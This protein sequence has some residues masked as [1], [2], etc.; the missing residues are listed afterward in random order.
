MYSEKPQKGQTYEIP[1]TIVTF[2]ALGADTGN[3][4]SLFEGRV[5]PRQGAPLHQ[6]SDDEAF[7]I[8]EGAF[9]FQIE[10]EYLQRE[11]NTI[12]I[13]NVRLGRSISCLDGHSSVISCL[14]FSPEG[15]IFASADFAGGII[16]WKTGFEQA[17]GNSLRPVAGFDFQPSPVNFD[18]NIKVWE[19]I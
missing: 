4:F 16:I 7:L 6:H 17:P 12:E 3:S 11:T 15:R 13:K 18:D 19:R 8:L 5:A 2:L 9:Q 1:S 10:D 14:K